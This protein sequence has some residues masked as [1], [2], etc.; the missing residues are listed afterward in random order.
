MSSKRILFSIL[1]FGIPVL[2]LGWLGYTASQDAEFI[3]LLEGP[4]RWGM[5]AAAVLVTL[6]AVVVTIIRWQMLA[7]AIGLNL[8]VR[9]ALRIGFLGYLLNLMAFGL[10]G[11]D[12][13]KATF[14]CR[15]E[16]KRKTE[17]VASVLIDRVVGL[18]ALLVLAAV[19][20]LV[21]D[22]SEVAFRTET[23]KRT[24]IGL[25]WFTQLAAAIATTGLV[26]LMLPGLADAKI[27]DR[28]GHLPVV[29]KVA[30]KLIAATR[31]YRRRFDQLAL[32]IVMSIG[33][34]SLYIAMV[35]FVAL[36]L[37]STPPS[38][39]SHFVIVPISMVAGALPIGTFEVVLDVLY[40]GISEV[41]IPQRQGFLIALTFRC[42][43][44]VV[45][46]VGIGYYL[47]SKSEMQQLMK[48]SEQ[49]PPADDAAPGAAPT[50]PA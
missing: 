35:Y 1:K 16:P 28:L 4:K 14:L 40:R 32:A 47:T 23:D 37:N 7:Q 33:V 30:A 29:G 49:P 15:I 20:S 41:A 12:A 38:I 22:F 26:L 9:D 42:I 13:L 48:S 2:L 10:V 44:L 46:T 21:I 17:A 43:Q 18:Y 36:G 8:G 34:H 31:M 11:G 6:L 45:A 24:I 39:A 19:A 50:T 27:W 25:C 5:L 3:L